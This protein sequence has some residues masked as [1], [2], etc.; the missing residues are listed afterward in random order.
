MRLYDSYGDQF[1]SITFQEPFWIWE[2]NYIIKVFP[3]D[4]GQKILMRETF[5]TDSFGKAIEF[6]EERKQRAIAHFIKHIEK[7]VKDKQK[8]KGCCVPL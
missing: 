7:V 3:I 8:K 4:K 6:F 2:K 1:C 5:T